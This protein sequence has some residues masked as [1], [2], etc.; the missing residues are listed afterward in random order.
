MSRSSGMARVAGVVAFTV[1]LAAS[2]PSWAIIIV[3]FGNW[4]ML[5]TQTLDIPVLISSDTDERISGADLHLHAGAGDIVVGA[6]I[7][8]V[9]MLDHATLPD[10]V[11]AAAPSQQVSY[12]DPWDVANGVST[13]L[14]PAFAAF[15]NAISG[16]DADVPVGT[17]SVLAWLTFETDDAPP[18]VYPISLTSPELGATFLTKITGTL[19][20][21]V[22]YILID[23][24]IYIEPEPSSWL[25]GLLAAAGVLSLG[26]RRWHGYVV[27][28]R[29][30]KGDL[31]LQ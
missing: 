29:P 15:C 16:P 21:D 19:E 8:A 9:G 28:Q 6:T 5:P 20:L 23:G 25:L 18:G 14:K 13:G 24:Q 1:A 12:G 10:P 31:Y 30:S 7:T 22:D 11:F 17:S 27:A 4:E 2:A 26:A 3:Q